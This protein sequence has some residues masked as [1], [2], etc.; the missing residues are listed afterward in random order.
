M[1]VGAAFDG[2]RVLV[3]NNGNNSVTIFKAAD[4]NPIGNV[5]TETSL[6]GHIGLQFS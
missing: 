1:P 2:E 5:S 3:T 4:L 6:V